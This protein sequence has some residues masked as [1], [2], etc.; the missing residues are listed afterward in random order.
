MNAG[1]SL[2]I[3]SCLLQKQCGELL[4][5]TKAG[6][7][8]TSLAG[9]PVCSLL[10]GRVKPAHPLPLPDGKSHPTIPFQ[11]TAISGTHTAPDTASHR[12]CFHTECHSIGLLTHYGTGNT[13]K[14]WGHRRGCNSTGE[15]EST[16]C[17]TL[18]FCPASAGG[19]ATRKV[20]RASK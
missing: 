9:M 1:T 6:W 14:A 11:V 17:T 5:V 10:P 16:K 15:Q 12:H 20:L 19:I 3:I 2:L 7:T 18:L 13:V 8:R 4:E